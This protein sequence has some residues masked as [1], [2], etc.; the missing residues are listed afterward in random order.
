MED[1]H[2][3]TEQQGA[4]WGVRQTGGASAGRV[5]HAERN[6]RRDS[7]GSDETL[8]PQGAVKHFKSGEQIIAQFSA[9]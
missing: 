4:L 2:P 8:Y 6:K 1:L 7:G 5:S 3:S 9:N